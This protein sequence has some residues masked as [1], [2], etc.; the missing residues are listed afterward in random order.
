LF[1]FFLYLR[2]FRFQLKHIVLFS[3][4]EFLLNYIRLAYWYFAAAFRS[5]RGIWWILRTIIWFIV[6]LV[7]SF[8]NMILCFLIFNLFYLFFILLSLF[9][10]SIPFSI[11]VFLFL[12]LEIIKETIIIFFSFEFSFRIVVLQPTVK[13]IIKYTGFCNY[14]FFYC[15]L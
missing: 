9:W 3:W 6:I 5:L 14:L 11:Y 7:F 15:L 10:I 4:C 1:L 12:L 13:E 8:I 2:W